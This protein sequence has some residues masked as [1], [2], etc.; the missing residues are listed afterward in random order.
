MEL[1]FLKPL[2]TSLVMP[3]LSLLLLAFLGLLLAS[4]K[5]RIGVPLAGL[6][7][8]LLWIVSSHGTAV[9]LARHALPQVAPLTQAALK[10]ARVQ[11]IVVL[12]GGVLPQAPEYGQ[13]QP[14][15]ATLARLRYGLW[16]AKQSGLPVA[17]TGGI[18]LAASSVQ[19]TAEADVAARVAWQDYGMTLR[20]QESRSRDTSE[21]ARM[22]APLLLGDSVHRIALVTDATHAPRATAAFERAG[23]RVLPAPIDYAFPT[24]SDALEWLP[25]ASGLQ[26]SHQVLHEW[27]ALV[28]G[29]WLAI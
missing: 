11:A 20:W 3:P 9:W 7:L 10:V 29:H 24:S 19:D 16:L 22:L 14:G 5:K 27:L 6:A 8:V 15:A 2:L 12:G 17:F 23:F 26:A 21:N 1:G 25:S 4:R 13:A 28:V 18:G